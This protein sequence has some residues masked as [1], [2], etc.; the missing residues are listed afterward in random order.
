MLRLV[1]KVGTQQH[2]QLPRLFMRCAASTDPF[3]NIA[4]LKSNVIVS[5]QISTSTLKA[6]TIPTRNASHAAINLGHHESPVAHGPLTEVNF[7]D[8]TSA[9][10]SKS[11][12]EVL[13]AIAV[14]KACRFPFLVK[15][16]DAMLNLSTKMFG[17]TITNA[18]VKHTFFN[19]FCAGEDS[20]DM[21]PVIEKLRKNN[22]G[23]IRKYNWS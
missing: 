17:S 1:G 16:A 12:F 11:T 8:A 4:A 19:H 21:K 20:V 18:V 22:I 13:R 14:F 5:R 3:R 7:E 10:G 9:H 6:S 2:G 23:P 15:H